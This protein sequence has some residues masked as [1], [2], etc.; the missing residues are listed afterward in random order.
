MAYSGKGKGHGKAMPPLTGEKANLVS[1]VKDLQRTDQDAKRKWEAFCT[2]KGVSKFDPATHDEEFLQEFLNLLENGELEVIESEEKIAL[3]MKVKAAQRRDAETKQMWYDFV[4]RTGSQSFDP[5]RHDETLLRDFL[6]FLDGKNQAPRCGSN[7]IFV[8]RLPRTGVTEASLKEYF[9]Q[10][11]E[12]T[13][14]ELKFDPEGNF[15]GF[16][17]VWFDTMEAA[18]AVVNNGENNLL[19]GHFIDCKP[20]SPTGTAPAAGGKAGGG[21]GSSK[22]A[23][24]AQPEPQEAWSGGAGWEDWGSEGWEGYDGWGWEE[25][26][27][28]VMA[29][30]AVAK[31]KGKGKPSSHPGPG[32]AGAS[33]KGG[34]SKGTPTTVPPR[35]KGAS[36]PPPRRDSRDA[37]TSVLRVRGMPFSTKEQDVADFFA[38]YDVSGR[39]ALKMGSDGRP[40]GEAF[41]EF[42]SPSEALRAQA[43]LN[44][45]TMGSRYVELLNANQ[46]DVDQYLSAAYGAAPEAPRSMGKGSGRPRPY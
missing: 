20:A 8:G 12:V 11:G 10:F 2:K 30:M 31:G 15:R 42:I 28:A 9:A 17:F 16:A 46:E 27:G 38:G 1:Q 39:V 45:A 37:S 21:K 25:M 34:Y 22:G 43:D 14:V 13:K 41:I 29:F 23:A 36:V 24:R 3:V 33:S 44:M 4:T 19:D 32:S 5:N 26:M 18:Q 6:D 35:G 40:S 7:Q